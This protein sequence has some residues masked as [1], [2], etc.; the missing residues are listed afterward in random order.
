MKRFIVRYYRNL[1]IREW[2]VWATTR[3]MARRTF[4]EVTRDIDDVGDIVQISEE[5]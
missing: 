5:A 1:H 3:Q 2:I 4:L